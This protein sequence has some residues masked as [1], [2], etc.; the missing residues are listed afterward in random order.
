LL[1]YHRSSP[2]LCPTAVACPSLLMSI[3]VPGC[4]RAL[5]ASKSR[6]AFQVRETPFSNV[7][8]PRPRILG[9]K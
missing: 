7:F 6:H 1:P 8:A 3:A 2:V 9:P 5:L 4:R